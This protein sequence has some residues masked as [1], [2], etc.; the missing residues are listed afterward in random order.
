MHVFFLVAGLAAAGPVWGL[1][2]VTRSLPVAILHEPYSPEPIQVAGGGGCTQ[3]F[4]AVSVARGDL[5]EGIWLSQA[6]Y[7]SGTPVQEGVYVFYVRASNGCQSVVREF[8]LRVNG[9]PILS[10]S[11][12]RLEFVYSYGGALPAAQQVRISSNWTNLRYGVEAV[13]APWLVLRPLR[14]AT[15]PAGSGLA[16]DTVAVSIDPERLAPG[17]YRGLI[18]ATAWRAVNEPEIA[19]TLVIR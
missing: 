10:A 13:R 16:A 11:V 3:N 1:E 19:V 12:E 7:F 2:I 15:P 4:V 5:P 9:A 14:G 18:K 17:N 6:G 8:T